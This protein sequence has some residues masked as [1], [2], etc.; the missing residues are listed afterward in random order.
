MHTES[1]KAF[2]RL[3]ALLLKYSFTFAGE[4]KRKHC[5]NAFVK[6]SKEKNNHLVRGQE[7]KKISYTLVTKKKKK[8]YGELR[9]HQTGLFTS[10]SLQ[11]M[12]TTDCVT[13]AKVT[14]CEIVSETATGQH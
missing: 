2:T 13:W 7:I 8:N 6:N 5:N 3:E 12:F 1:Y 9:E 4:T 14:K 10:T 11:D